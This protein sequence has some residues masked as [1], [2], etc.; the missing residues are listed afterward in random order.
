MI[1]MK[2]FVVSIFAVAMFGT[3]A[4]AQGGGQPPRQP[5]QPPGPGGMGPGKRQ[6]GERRMHRPG[7]MRQRMGGPGRIDFNRLNLTDAQ[8]Q[9]I[10]ALMENQRRAGEAN[11]AQFE[12]MANLMRLKREGLLTTEQGT[13]L[14]ALEAQM[15][16]NGDR[17][18]SDL[19]AILTPEQRTLVEQMRNERGRMGGMR[20]APRMPMRRM[21][22][23]PNAPARPN[24]PPP[25]PPTQNN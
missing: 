1:S 14:T 20:R 12:E 19:M 25:P 11:R 6:F 3:F 22:R 2:N 23:A 21:L 8:K 7:M 5:N 13:R 4:M 24:N 17:F 15:K 18:Q 10:Q 9:R 16:T